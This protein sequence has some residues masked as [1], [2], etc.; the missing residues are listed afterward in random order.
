[1]K[2]EKNWLNIIFLYEFIN[3]LKIDGKIEYIY[4]YINK[5]MNRKFMVI[6]V[7][8]DFN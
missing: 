6:N 4:K 1:M 2:L 3:I 8:I 7:W 5:K